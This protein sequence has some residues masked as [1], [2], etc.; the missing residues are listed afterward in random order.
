MNQ[1]EIIDSHIKGGCF[2]CPQCKIE[3][4]GRPRIEN[5][6]EESTQVYCNYGCGYMFIN[7]KTES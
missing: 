7:K 4:Y 1:N 6:G 3:W 2:R 5:E